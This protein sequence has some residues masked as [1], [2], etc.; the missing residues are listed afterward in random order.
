MVGREAKLCIIIDY[1]CVWLSGLLLT[2]HGL[3][4]LP[5]LL[6]QAWTPEIVHP[7]LV[8]SYH[9]AIGDPSPVGWHAP[10]SI[11]MLSTDDYNQGCSSNYKPMTPK[12]QIHNTKQDMG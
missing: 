11:T 3:A 7:F 6:H 10:K 1:G 2:K 12:C 9:W 8:P 4:W 5:A